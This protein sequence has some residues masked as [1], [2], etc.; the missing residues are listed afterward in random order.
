MVKSG[1]SG[2]REIIATAFRKGG[3]ESE[4]RQLALLDQDQ[5]NVSSALDEARSEISE[6]VQARWAVLLAALVQQFPEVRAELQAMIENSEQGPDHEAA[7]ASIR[8]M[9]NINSQ[10]VQAGGNISTGGGS[11]SYGSSRQGDE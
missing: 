4:S 3:E 2:T 5:E 8:A 11:I 10:I 7:A 6:N 1:W 9:N